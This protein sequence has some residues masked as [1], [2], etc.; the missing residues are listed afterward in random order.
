MLNAESEQ[1]IM[2][3]LTKDQIGNLLPRY[4]GQTPLEL[5]F[6]LELQYAYN[7]E[8]GFGLHNCPVFADDA[9]HPNVLIVGTI[10][11]WL[12]GN[13]AYNK[14]DG[15]LCDWITGQYAPL[16]PGQRLM[17]NLCSP[18]WEA[19]LEKLLEGYKTKKWVRF[20]HRLN[21]KLFAQHAGWR[22]KLPAGFEMRYYYDVN[23]RESLGRQRFGFALMKGDTKASECSAVYYEKEACDS[24]TARVVEIGIE[25]KEEYRRRGFALLTCAAFIEYCLSHDLEP[26]WG[27][28]DWNRGSQALAKKLGFEEISRRPVLVLERKK[29]IFGGRRR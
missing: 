1:S 27:C 24:E 15:A 7:G 14:S 3:E 11:A 25:T 2:K 20:N 5:Q 8:N 13:A 19:K 12:V 4:T 26:N 21:R 6:T 29:K 9:E 18:G 16:A 23:A 22:E 28:W 10:W 17:L